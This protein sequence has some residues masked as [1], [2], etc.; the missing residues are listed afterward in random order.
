[1]GICLGAFRSVYCTRQKAEPGPPARWRY[2]RLET[3]SRTQRV[4]IGLH[5][6]KFALQRALTA[7]MT[8]QIYICRYG[9]L[10]HVE[11]A[12]E[13]FLAALQFRFGG[14]CV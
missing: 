4:Y 5:R 7:H 2:W 11:T 14:I 3:F 9:D 8:T 10:V 6:L 12:L 13:V 1:M